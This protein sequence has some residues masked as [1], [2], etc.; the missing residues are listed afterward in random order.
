MDT[1]PRVVGASLLSLAFLG[2]D[3][4]AQVGGLPAPSDALQPFWSQEFL[5]NS[6]VSDTRRI[7]VESL[8]AP[9]ILPASAP[10]MSV[11]QRIA[12]LQRGEKTYEI[13]NEAFRNSGILDRA[14]RETPELA[15]SFQD[16]E[17][18]TLQKQQVYHQA[19][20]GNMD[21]TEAQN[22]TSQVDVAQQQAAEKFEADLWETGFNGAKVATVSSNSSASSRRSNY[23]LIDSIGSSST[24]NLGYTITAIDSTG[25]FGPTYVPSE[26]LLPLPQDPNDLF[27]SQADSSSSQRAPDG[28]MMMLT[29]DKTLNPIVQALASPRFGVRHDTGFLGS[30]NKSFAERVDLASRRANAAGQTDLFQ[31][32]DLLIPLDAAVNAQI[33]DIG[34]GTTGQVFFTAN[35]DLNLNEMRVDTFGVR[36]YVR[37]RGALFEG[38]S[39]VA[40]AKQSLFGAIEL[41]PQGLDGSRT[42]IGTVDTTNANRPQLAI[43]APINSMLAWK[44]AVEKPSDDDV[45]FAASTPAR[46]LL[47]RWPT[48]A[49]NLTLTDPTSNEQIHLGALVRSIGYQVNTTGREE[50]ATGWGVNAIAKLNGWN[51]TNFVGVAGGN[52]IGDYIRGISTSVVGSATSIETIYGYG[53]FAGRQVV[54]KD[55]CSVPT[56]EFNLAYG[57]GLMENP[58]TLQDDTNRKFHQFWTNYFKYFG[59][60]SGVGAEY[61][62]GLRQVASGDVG[63]NHQFSIMLAMRTGKAQKQTRVQEFA[64][65][66]PG[67]GLD[68]DLADGLD[69]QVGA[70]SY[71]NSLPAPATLGGQSVQSVIQQNQLGGPAFQQGL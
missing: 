64:T 48:V 10:P 36:A 23:F 41:K 44:V 43:H 13:S 28:W 51:G 15:L 24:D 29:E 18:R 56:A 22:A 33:L 52:G 16:F 21:A 12:R 38:W 62:Y 6:H 49:T 70:N 35:N 61:Q 26:Y 68:A 69:G 42:L 47:T 1:L 2:S 7:Q 4:T 60:R 25:E 57:Y 67:R 17:A 40:G 3:V 31:D 39:L 32:G 45:L 27:F 50:F 30:G 34:G 54:F 5:T 71:S 19:T 11:R 58:T 63:E 55:K 65:A 8:P 66:Q 14:I 20:S 46:T 9:G 53:A 59:D 37:R